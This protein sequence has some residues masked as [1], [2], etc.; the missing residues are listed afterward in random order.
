MAEIICQWYWLVVVMALWV[1]VA[2]GLGAKAVF[3][4]AEA[5]EDEATG[6]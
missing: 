1:A 5:K 3:F 4:D 2:L 6:H